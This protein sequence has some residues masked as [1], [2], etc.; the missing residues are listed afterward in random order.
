MSYRTFNLTFV[1]G[2]VLFVLFNA[3]TWH[4]ALRPLLTRYQGM[5]I[6]DL[7]RLG[8]VT[9]L[10]QP[11]RNRTTLPRRHLE[12][13]DYEGGPVDLLTIGDSFSNGGAGGPN[14]YYQDFIASRLG[15]KVLNLRILPG[16]HDIDTINILLNNGILQRIHPRYLLL[17]S[18]ARKVT[19]RYVSPPDWHRNMERA[20]IDA[21]YRFGS[22]Q[23]G[24]TGLELPPVRFINTGNIKYWWNRLMYRLDDCAFTSKACRVRL[25]APRF[26]VGDGR[27][28]LFYRGDLHA[29]HKH[30]PANVRAIDD[31]LNA[32]HARLA[33]AG[34]QLIFMPVV[35]KYG[36]Y[37]PDFSDPDYEPD[38]LFRL[39][40]KQPAD[41]PW[42]DTEAILRGA[43]NRGEKD[44]FYID[45]SHW[46]P[47]ASALIAQ[48]LAR[49]VAA[50]GG[51]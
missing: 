14:R 22:H 42:I 5:V 25:R 9:D 48:A 33:A 1:A 4:Y 16:T 28:M 15:W 32:L 35:T 51:D 40:R 39:L 41:Y 13:A 20:R 17:E 27:E 2:A 49:I 24:A 50:Q 37:Q 36:L 29:L 45:D 38:P 46:T 7:A 30:T 43:V 26:S 12:A 31:T 19:S 21:Y 34:I 44:V 23:A 47:K 18:T 6:G 3:L 11:R 10:V 8:Y